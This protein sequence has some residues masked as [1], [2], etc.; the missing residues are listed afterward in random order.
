MA[1]EWG[2]AKVEILAIKDE[3]LS[4]IEEGHTLKKIYEEL[5]SSGRITAGRAIF[6]RHVS[7]LRSTVFSDQTANFQRSA[8]TTRQARPSEHHSKLSRPSGSDQDADPVRATASLGGLR[9]DG[10]RSTSSA[11]RIDD[12]LWGGSGVKTRGGSS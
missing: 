4:R 10:P 5:C 1:A 9:F 8:N 6:Y 11:P 2:Q 7:R 3:I 12:D